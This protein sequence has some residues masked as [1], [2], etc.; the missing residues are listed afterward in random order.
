LPILSL[1]AKKKMVLVWIRVWEK[2]WSL[3]FG[4]VESLRACL[5]VGRF[6]KSLEFGVWSWA[7]YW[8]RSVR[9]LEVSAF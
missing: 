5:P 7:T 1:L 3:E 8:F 6:G 9:I 4:A 2:V